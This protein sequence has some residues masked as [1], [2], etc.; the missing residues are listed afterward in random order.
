L[1]GRLEKSM[2]NIILAI[3]FYAA[4]F[5]VVCFIF[6]YL[7]IFFTTQFA[8]RKKEKYETGNLKLLQKDY[9]KIEVDLTNAKLK[10]LNLQTSNEPQS[11]GMITGIGMALGDKDNSETSIT[12]SVSKFNLKIKYK[13]QTLSYESPYLHTDEITLL[14]LLN[15]K[16]QLLPISA[17]IFQEK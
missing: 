12:K 9:N 15:E 5:I 17:L 2:F 8:K 13:G 4:I 7:V 14:F 10:Q 1:L 16:R 11:V 6:F 3:P